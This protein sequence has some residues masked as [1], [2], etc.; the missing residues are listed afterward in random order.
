MEI[1]FKE[2]FGTFAIADLV[3]FIFL[4]QGPDYGLDDVL[5]F[6]FGLWCKVHFRRKDVP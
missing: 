6:F 2:S 5:H 4:F 1:F 3:L